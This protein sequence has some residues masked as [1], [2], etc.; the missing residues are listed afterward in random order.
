M[1]FMLKTHR[2][3]NVAESEMMKSKGTITERKRGLFND[4]VITYS[5]I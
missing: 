2:K 5:H 3:V 4:N 1:A